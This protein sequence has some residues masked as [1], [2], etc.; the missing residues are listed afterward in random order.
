MG[1]ALTVKLLALEADMKRRFE[2]HLLRSAWR[3]SS[4]AELQLDGR[5][6]GPVM[7]RTPR[8]P[9]V[10]LTK[11]NRRSAKPLQRC[12]NGAANVLRLT[13]VVASVPLSGTGGRRVKCR[14]QIT[15][16]NRLQIAERKASFREA[17]NSYPDGRRGFPSRDLPADSRES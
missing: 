11:V 5:R 17:H 3:P 1:Q 14:W 16:M 6:C 7:L 4:K 8:L 13:S 15:Q 12:R 2:H 10:I 9:S